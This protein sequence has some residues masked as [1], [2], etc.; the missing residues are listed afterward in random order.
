MKTMDIETFLDNTKLFNHWCKFSTFEIYLVKER[1]IVDGVPKIVGIST[2]NFSNTRRARNVCR[3]Y[4]YTR[5]GRFDWLLA[6]IDAQCAKHGYDYFRI[7][8]I[9]NEFLPEVLIKKGFRY[10]RQNGDDET[11]TMGSSFIRGYSSEQSNCAKELE[12]T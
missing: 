5:T 6:H 11:Y 10:V 7:D 12:T 1:K 2:S 3:K 4:K 8:S 9:V